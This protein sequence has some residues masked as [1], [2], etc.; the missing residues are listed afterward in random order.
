MTKRDYYET[1]GVSRDAS[2]NDLKS[3]FRGLARQYHPDVN[4]APDAEERF[5]EINEAYAVLSDEEKKAAYDRFGHAGLNG[6]GG[7]PDFSSFDFTDIFEELFGF[8]FGGGARGRRRRNVPRRGQD[9]KYNLNLEFEEAIFGVEKE[10]EITRDEICN[11]CDGKRAE[12]GTNSITCPTCNGAGEV[13][14]SRQTLFGS[15]MQVTSCPTCSG[16]GQVIETPCTTCNGRGLE[17]KTVK[18]VVSV[19]GGVDNGQQIRLSG[20]GQPGINGGPPGDIYM[21]IRV[22]QH[23]YFR[24]RKDDIHLDLDINVA[25]AALGAE[26]EVPTVDGSST[27]SLVHNQEKCS[28]CA[29]KEFPIYVVKGVVTN[30]WLS[31]SRYPNV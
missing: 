1:L 28:V 24:R 8:G 13:R 15:M 30:W 26:V 3:A 9:L 19:P 5:K 11:H 29:I 23:Q 2:Q 16:E 17:R 25:Q 27:L 4:D 20:E 10:V 7:V 12:P 14:T 6:L 18:K 21:A 22:K 31:M